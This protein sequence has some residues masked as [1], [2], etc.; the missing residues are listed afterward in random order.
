M[1]KIPTIFHRDFEYSNG[2][3]VLNEVVPGCEWVLAGEGV[4]TRK[5]DGTCVMLDVDGDW[6]ARREVKKGKEAPT[7][8]VLIETDDETGKSVGWEPIAQSGF[9]K[10]FEEAIAGEDPMPGTYELIGPKING[11]PEHFDMHVLIP[12]GEFVIGDAPRTFDGLKDYLTGADGKPFPFE[13]IVWH[14][15]DGRMAKLKVRDFPKEKKA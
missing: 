3:Y 8:F 1:N 11:N 2:R 13:G 15:E 7:G 12:H 5:Y 6:W 9:V 10:F 14:H 4:A